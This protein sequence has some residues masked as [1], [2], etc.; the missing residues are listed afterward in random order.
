MTVLIWLD[1]SEDVIEKFEDYHYYD[2]EPVERV[3]VFT[4][5]RSIL[6]KGFYF[7]D[8]FSFIRWLNHLW[9]DHNILIFLKEALDD[10]ENPYFQDEAAECVLLLCQNSFQKYSTEFH[11]IFSRKNERISNH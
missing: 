3:A 5:F 9:V 7:F 11:R 2:E 10:E 8:I 4:T 6:S 1:F